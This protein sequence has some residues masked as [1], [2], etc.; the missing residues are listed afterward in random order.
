MFTMDAAQVAYERGDESI[1]RMVAEYQNRRD[2]LVDALTGLGYTMARPSG[3]FYA[4][5]EVPP[6]FDGSSYDYARLLARRAKVA[7]IP[8]EA[9]VSGPSRYVRFSYA[10]SLDALHEAVNRIRRFREQ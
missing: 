10:A 5:V 1:D 9:F 7:G 2:Y 8:G 3:A 4:Y 6:I